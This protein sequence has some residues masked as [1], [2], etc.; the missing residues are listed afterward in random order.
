MGAGTGS[1]IS[2]QTYSVTLTFQPMPMNSGDPLYTNFLSGLGWL[3][4]GLKGVGARG[5]FTERTNPLG[6]VVSI[7]LVVT[8]P[9]DGADRENFNRAFNRLLWGVKYRK[10]PAL[11]TASGISVSPSDT[12]YIDEQT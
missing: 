5:S 4:A 10:S 12:R 8:G 2:G 11:P 9:L 3:L 7:S 1:L 6:A